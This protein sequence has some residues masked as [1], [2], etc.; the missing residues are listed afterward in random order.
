MMKNRL[1]N[2]V[3]QLAALVLAF[4]VV[5]LILLSVAVDYLLLRAVEH[6]RGGAGGVRRDCN[7]LGLPPLS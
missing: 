3:Y 6:W 1:I 7:H 5:S 2:L 4:G